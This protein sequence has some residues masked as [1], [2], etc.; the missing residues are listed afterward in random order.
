MKKLLFITLLILYVCGVASTVYA[1]SYQ[2]DIYKCKIELPIGW[3]VIGS[4]ANDPNQDMLLL[5]KQIPVV[6]NGKQMAAIIAIQKRFL[7]STFNT[8]N[9]LSDE[10][11]EAIKKRYMEAAIDH[12][13]PV[14]GFVKEIGRHKAI[15]I[16]RSGPESKAIDIDLLENK[17]LWDFHVG[18]PLEYYENIVFELEEIIKSFSMI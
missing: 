11:V 16:V 10:K 9:E 3:Y 17:Y 15:W 13:I 2:N 14:E 7:N 5:Y 6:K 18:V 1:Q 8:F 4:S 12:N